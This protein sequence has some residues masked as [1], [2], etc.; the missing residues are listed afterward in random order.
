[1]RGNVSSVFASVASYFNCFICRVAV[2][3]RAAVCVI[4][5]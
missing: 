2:A 4:R 5:I 1:M 3:V